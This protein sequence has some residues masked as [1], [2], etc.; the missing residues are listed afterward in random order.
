MQS[1]LRN[2]GG[3][4][5][6]RSSP[7]H[8]SYVQRMQNVAARPRDTQ[9]AVEIAMS[10]GEV[11]ETD[12]MYYKG[13]VIQH[14]VCRASR[15]HSAIETPSRTEAQL[16]ENIS[17]AWI[18]LFGPMRTL[19]TDPESGLNTANATAHLKRLGTNLKVRGKDQHARYI[20]R[21]GAIL[22]HA[23]H[24][25]DTQAVR[26]GIGIDLFFKDLLAQC[27][28]CGNSLTHVGGS[29]PYQVVFGR[30]PSMLP[31]ITD[32]PGL[33]D[34]REARIREI[35]L[36]SMISATSATRV[37]RAVKVPT[38][39]T[40][41][42]RFK[43][44]DLVELYRT[45]S[46]KDVSGWSGP[47]GVVESRAHDGV[48]VVSING[49]NRPYRIQDVRHTMFAQSLYG[50]ANVVI[51]QNA[52][53]LIH[54]FLK[55][56]SAGRTETFGLVEDS[57]GNPIV[58]RTTKR[59]P[60]VARSLNHLIRTSFQLYDVCSV[61][62]GRHV[63]KLP[64]QAGP[65]FNITF[66]WDITNPDRMSAYTA[67]TAKFN[68]NDIFGQQEPH[69]AIMQC[70]CLDQSHGIIMEEIVDSLPIREPVRQDRSS[71]A[72]S[73]NDGYSARL[74]TTPEEH[75]ESNRASSEAEILFLQHFA[76]MT[77]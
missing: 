66:N 14:F 11:V 56:L 77:S 20:E 76:L 49:I 55:Q 59:W 17:T 37:A 44:D 1:I 42:D 25:M 67:E 2:A 38:T 19:V 64:G 54:A 31:P 13:Y 5:S 52:L 21:R 48:I 24:V 50:T 27:V 75:T 60:K 9:P 6:H 32:D 10:F 68:V 4:S 36:Q 53:N 71:H 26:E 22:R 65:Q 73:L 18:S 35:A 57:W 69:F 41:A 3:A 58:T 72:Q 23:L 40:A 46:N 51:S 28:F 8:N 63:H 16:L 45:P 43:P 70:F 30:Q 47:Y 34:R 61:R 29:T 15:W 7:Q 12:L 39:L 62:I 74:S 33:N